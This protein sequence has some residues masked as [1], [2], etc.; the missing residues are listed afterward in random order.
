MIDDLTTALANLAAIITGRSSSDVEI[1]GRIDGA[2][3]RR[4]GG[5][6]ARFE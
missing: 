4:R 2:D 1:V 5:L 6:E 3:V